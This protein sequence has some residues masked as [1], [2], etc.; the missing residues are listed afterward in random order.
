VLLVAFVACSG[1]GLILA[2]DTGTDR[3]ARRNEWRT[4]KS[5]GPAAAVTDGLPDVPAGNA[6]TI[7][8]LSS[9]LRPDVSVLQKAHQTS[10]WSNRPITPIMELTV[11]V[12]VQR[13]KIAW[14]P[15]LNTCRHQRRPEPCRDSAAPLGGTTGDDERDSVAGGRR[16]FGSL[17][18]RADSSKGNQ[19]TAAYQV[20]AEMD[21]TY[22]ALRS[23]ADTL[24][25][26]HPFRL[27]AR[28]HSL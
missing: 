8:L 18:V 14:N 28:S 26:D 24:T 16:H 10:F 15:R 17:S 12:F 22:L 2:S 13:I 25:E 9:Y 20:A 1:G 6:P 23:G 21:S 27:P 3:S 5:I 11:V 7:R 19:S 4:V